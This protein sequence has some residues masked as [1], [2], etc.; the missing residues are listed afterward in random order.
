VKEQRPQ[1][2][3]P[4]DAAWG[5]GGAFVPVVLLM[6]LWVVAYGTVTPGGGF[7]GGV[8]IAAALLLIWVVG[9]YQI[10]RRVTPEV[11]IHLAEGT[12]L[13]GILAT[14]I[15]GLSRHGSYLANVLPLGTAGEIVSGGTI[16]LLNAFTGLAVGAALLLL[17]CE[18]LQEH[19]E[20]LPGTEE[21]P[22]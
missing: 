16:A 5:F 2:A 14:G 3:A 6:G 9:S 15:V 4:T 1:D 10:F 20:T 21:E 7:Q 13:L 17:L 11:L 18:F 22:P 19:I 12:A 8:V